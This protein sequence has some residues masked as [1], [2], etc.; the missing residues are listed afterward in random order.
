[1]QLP[2]YNFATAEIVVKVSL[3]NHVQ[4]LSRRTAP[5]YHYVSLIIGNADNSVIF[6][7]K[8]M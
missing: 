8:L 1:M 3:K 4:L 2:R 6:L 5:N 7:Q